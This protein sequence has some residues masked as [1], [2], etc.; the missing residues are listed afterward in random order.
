M[1]KILLVDDIPD[2]RDYVRTLLNEKLG[3]VEIHEGRNGREAI[4]L[5]RQFQPDLVLM[6]I[7]MPGIQG[8]EATRI[9]HKALPDCK[10]L[11]LTV[12]AGAAFA[13]LSRKAGASGYLLKN[14]VDQELD[15]AINNIMRNE[16]YESPLT[17][18]SQN[19]IE[20]DRL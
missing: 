3:S 1:L 6:D 18:E 13:N 4:N 15:D 19:R 14:L 11:I 16:W 5:A 2:F 10:I 8:I 12:N 7:S 9:I 20:G 17:H